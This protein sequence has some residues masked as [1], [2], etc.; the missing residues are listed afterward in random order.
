[1]VADGQVRVT[2]GARALVLAETV[3]GHVENRSSPYWS[4]LRLV[5]WLSDRLSDMSW[6][7]SSTCIRPDGITSYLLMS[8]CLVVFAP[9][10]AAV[11]GVVAEAVVLQPASLWP[12]IRR[13]YGRLKQTNKLICIII[14]LIWAHAL[15][16]FIT[17]WEE[18]MTSGDVPC[19]QS[20]R[21][22][23]VERTITSFLVG[24]EVGC[25]G[26]VGRQVQEWLDCL[27][28]KFYASKLY[29]CKAR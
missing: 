19:S 9:S 24:L 22:N 15:P 3:N 2:W 20:E 8:P 14:L 1:M 23:S 16:W 27:G 6:M 21:F 5:T 7:T 18:Q 13:F 25:E 4:L 10:K 11:H 26:R 28:S 12:Y 17:P 29:Q